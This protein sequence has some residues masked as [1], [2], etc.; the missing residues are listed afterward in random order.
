MKN[1]FSYF[2]SVPVRG[3]RPT[4]I[5]PLTVAKGQQRRLA[6]QD[7]PGLERPGP[8]A[9]RG[10]RRKPQDQEDLRVLPEHPPDA[11][12]AVAD[13]QVHRAVADRLPVLVGDRVL[14]LVDRPER[15]ARCTRPR[16]PSGTSR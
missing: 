6:H 3:V 9:R 8:V 2:A 16:A 5:E 10:G 15:A 11:D 14:V 12:A 7:Q 13:A 4:P 1:T